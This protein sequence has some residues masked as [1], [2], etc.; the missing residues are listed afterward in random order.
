[1]KPNQM[2]FGGIMVA[3]FLQLAVAADGAETRSASRSKSGSFSV[4]T[5]NVAGLPEPLSGSRPITNTPLISP[6]LNDFDIV[7]CQED[8]YYHRFLKAEAR[9]PFISPSS[10][11]GTLGDGLS[12][13][14][15]FPFSE[16]EHISWE[17]C[18]GRLAYGSD[19]LTPKGFS[20]AVHEIA[21][22]VFI[23]IYDLHM[24][25]GNN[26]KD[27]DARDAEMTQ[28]LNWMA[29]KSSGKPVIVGGDWNLNCRNQR[30][31]AILERILEHENLTDAC[32]S[33]SCGDERIDKILFRGSDSLQLKAVRY[34]VESERFRDRRG[35]PL[36]D[37]EPVMVVFEW[38]YSAK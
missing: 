22:G 28:L 32:R 14:S 8:F 35:A 15:N 36:S 7:L 34:Q 9:H 2:F 38:E 23:D 10:T 17:K 11:L 19:C 24:D 30:E 13:F 25:A 5:Y 18:H 1:M 6:R 31:R 29:E 27:N 12:R 33:L 37:H 4:L 16:V 20:F 26:R 3:V 21:P